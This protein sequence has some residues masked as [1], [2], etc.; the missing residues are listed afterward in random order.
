MRSRRT[1]GLV[2]AAFTSLALVSFPAVTSQAAPAPDPAIPV[3]DAHE[4]ASATRTDTIIVT[5]DRG[6]GDP[7]KA[8]T[9]AV[10]AAAQGIADAR[11]TQVTPI[12]AGMVAVTLDTSLTSGEQARLGSAVE[13]VAGVKAAEPNLTYQLTAT[14]DPTGETYWDYQWNLG[15]RWGIKAPQAWSQSTGVGAVVGVVDTGITSHPDLTGSGTAIVGGNVVAGYDFITTAASAQ[16]GDGRDADPTDLVPDDYFHG[17]HVAGIIGARLDGD[18]IVG[19]APSVRIQPL[20]AMGSGG[21]SDADIMAAMRW[22]AGLPVPGTPTNGTPVDVLNL[23]LGGHAACSVAMQDTVTAI[24]ARGV[25]I[26]VSAGNSGEAVENSSPANCKGVIRVTAT[27]ATGLL[28]DYSNYGTAAMPATIAAPGGSG[29]PNPANGLTGAIVSTWHEGTAVDGGPAYAGMSGTSMA[30]PHVSGVAA[31]LKSLKKA[32]TPAQ[33]TTVLQRTAA[34]L[35]SPCTVSTCGTG[36]LDAAAA[37]RAEAPAPVAPTLTLK[38]G[39][40]IKGTPVVART[41]SGTAGTWSKKAT[42]KRRWLRDG[43]PISGATAARYRTRPADVG[44][45]LTFRVIAIRAGY[46]ATTAA[47]TPVR[48][49]PGTLRVRKA[50]GITGKRTAGHSLAGHVGKWRPTPKLARQWLCDGLAIAGATRSTW[51]L[52]A[53]DRGHTLQVRVTATRAGYT[54]VVVTSAPVLIR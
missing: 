42:L 48:I 25:A 32:L 12:S 53:A 29:I 45:D 41:L 27:G 31:L 8:A 17:T 35:A 23:S 20:R 14:G 30:A 51:K 46:A 33:I 47:S 10:E 22:G 1:F 6:S 16:D 54:T 43:Q 2:T 9:E 28:A 50:P 11:I 19:T 18:G 15:G 7:A 36:I 4:R 38:K 39:P 40:A 21:G 5:F 34:P 26:V 24:V 37:V 49:R 13:D 3:F 44:H 52:T